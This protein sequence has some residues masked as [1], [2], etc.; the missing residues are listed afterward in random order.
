MSLLAFTL[1]ALFVIA[2]SFASWKAALYWHTRNR[3]ARSEDPRDQEIREL[4]AAL[5]IARKELAQSSGTREQLCR[6]SN[7]LREKLE[8]VSDSLANTTQKFNAAKEHLEHESKA[9][10]DSHELIAQLRREL[11]QARTRSTEL[12]VQAKLALNDQSLVTSEELLSD[13]VDN[14]GLAAARAEATELTAELNRWKQHCAVLT[15]SNKER[16]ARIRQLE[17]LQ[18]SGVVPVAGG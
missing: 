7:E 3:D 10:E 14:D 12:E 11:D 8:H 6:E 4:G 5:S 13:S 9:R 16:R 17:S 18:P 2:G 1:S 15:A